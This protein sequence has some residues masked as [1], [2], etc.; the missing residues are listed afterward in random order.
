MTEQADDQVD[1]PAG[2]GPDST[3]EVPDDAPVFRLGY[4]PGATPG[5][6]A[7]TWRDR[8][9][10]VR[11]EL[12][13]VEAADAAAALVDRRVDAAVLR[14]PVDGDVLHAIP[15]YTEVPVV[16]VSRDHLIAATTEDEVVTADDLAD[17]VVWLP[18][19]DVL[20]ADGGPVPGRAPTSADPG[21]TEDLR[22]ATTAEAIQW[23]AT[24][25][26]VAV[27][28]MSL[29]RLHH[30]KDVTS[31]VLDGGPGAPVGLA[32]L[33]E[34]LSDEE[35]ELVEEMI[36]IVRGRTVNSSRGRAGRDRGEAAE[37][38]R[39]AGDGGR[40]GRAAGRREG[41]RGGKQPP[42]R[43]PRGGGK[44]GQGRGR[45]GRGRR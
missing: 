4:V 38:S 44:P 37:P 1:D 24:G 15:L 33:V 30:R 2:E 27:V 3:P 5:R 6:W 14:L 35:R 40:T 21:S 10:D 17:D 32:W 29:A 7:G 41:G 9:P 19:D 25:V 8:L 18:M 23:V 11:L 34:G 31:R 28:P 45:G 39:G 36:G 43:R 20:F 42:A 26:G 13:Q 16:V 22:P 12:V